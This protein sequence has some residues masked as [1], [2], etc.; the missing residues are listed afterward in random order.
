V[1]IRDEIEE[2][3]RHRAATVRQHEPDDQDGERAG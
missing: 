1:K 2:G 3:R